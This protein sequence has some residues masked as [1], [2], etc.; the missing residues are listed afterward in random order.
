VQLLLLAI[1]LAL[2]VTTSSACAASFDC[3]SARSPLEKN[4]CADATLS[5]ADEVMAGVYNAQ[6]VEAP[7]EFR[8]HL[9]D[10]Q[11][12]WLAYVGPFCLTPAHEHLECLRQQ[13]K[14][15]TEEL[16]K[17]V[18]QVAPLTFFQASTYAVTFN[19]DRPDWAF[20]H[21]SAFIQV[22]R[23]K[24]RATRQWNRVAIDNLDDALQPGEDENDMEI[25]VRLSGA[26][27]ELISVRFGTSYYSAS[28]AHPQYSSHAVVW[29]LL[30]GRP[31]A[32]TDLFKDPKAGKDRLAQQALT[33]FD[34]GNS[35][36]GATLTAIRESLDGAP[37]WEATPAGLL[38]DYDPYAF[39]CYPCT[40]HALVP[41]NE[42]AP[43]LR[44]DL[45][46]AVKNLRD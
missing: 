30:L 25:S 2:S 44:A 42:L 36:G 38:L 4:I 40:G 10:S 26:S 11:R 6:F 29:S 13:F 7:S 19:P 35:V 17:T 37:N 45:P 28:M 46:F 5:Q 3:R 15:R 39:G 41:W 1:A 12:S 21:K 20:T 9:R 33:H 31:L 27:A 24:S 34:V 16:G 18:R 8:Q 23:P 32:F 43:Y 14:D 22:A